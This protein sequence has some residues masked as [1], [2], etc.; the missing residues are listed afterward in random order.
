MVLIGLLAFG[1]DVNLL[2]QEVPEDLKM[3]LD[4]G[5]IGTFKDFLED[6]EHLFKL[7]EFEFV[8]GLHQTYNREQLRLVAF[9]SLWIPV[10]QCSH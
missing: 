10:H 7:D 4:I 1:D 6:N 8:Y 3:N 5:S 2:Y 9:E